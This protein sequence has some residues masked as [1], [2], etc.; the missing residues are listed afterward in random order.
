VVLVPVGGEG[1]PFLLQRV[2][3]PKSGKNRKHVDLPCEDI[4]EAADDLVAHGAKRL[5]EPIEELG[6]R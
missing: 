1:P 5:S 6:T 3:E 2:G 4:A